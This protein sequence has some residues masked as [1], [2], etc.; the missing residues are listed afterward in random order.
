ML[1]MLP[2]FTAAMLVMASP[3]AMRPEAGALL[4]ASAGF[5]PMLMASPRTVS[6]P[7][8][9]TAQSATGVCH[10]PTIWSRW[11]KPPT[12]RSLMVIRK[13]LAATVGRRRMRSTLSR[14]SYF[15]A[16]NVVSG[17]L[18]VLSLRVVLGGLPS[19]T[20]SGKS[21]GLLSNTSS[22]TRK[23]PSSVAVPTTANGQRSRSQMARKRSKSSGKIAST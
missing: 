8:R 14:K 13:F 19:N 21:T 16:S 3:N 6:K 11:V 18:T 5:S 2:M 15:A 23:C 10:A 7:I 20:L 4:I 17:W 9:V 22:R 12:L 1:P